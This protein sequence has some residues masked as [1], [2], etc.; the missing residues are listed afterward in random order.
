[1]IFSELFLSYFEVSEL[2]GVG[3]KY[4]SSFENKFVP[5]S[6]SPYFFE[7]PLIAGMTF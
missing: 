1:M 6:L 3:V 2:S 4:L 7:A 5:N